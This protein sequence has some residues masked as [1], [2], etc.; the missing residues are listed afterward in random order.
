MKPENY[1]QDRRELAGWPVTVESYGLNGVYHCTIYSIEPGAR[2]T[3]ADGGT[4][5]EAEQR[6]IE[7]AT[8]YL[9][10][11]RRFTIAE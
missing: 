1:T 10:Q 4:R 7:R 2:I 11:T 9:S 5:E 3:R 6:A 8:K